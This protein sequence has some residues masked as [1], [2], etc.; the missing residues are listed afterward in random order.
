LWWWA[1]QGPAWGEVNRNP[2]PSRTLPVSISSRRRGRCRTSPKPNSYK[3][4]RSS[5]PT[6][7]ASRGRRPHNRPATD[8]GNH[9]GRCDE[10]KAR[11][12]AFLQR[13]C[14]RRAVMSQTEHV[15]AP[16]LRLE[17][18][19]NACTVCWNARKP[20]AFL[21]KSGLS[22]RKAPSSKSSNVGFRTVDF[23]ARATTIL[24]TAF[25]RSLA[26]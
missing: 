13:E 10:R 18:R 5:P 19:K 6:L 1:P 3:Q 24:S 23:R 2:R 14:R 11:G 20:A 17:R 8:L 4:R 12:P 22:S 21:F 25:R 9:R 16:R 15:S 26:M 7:N